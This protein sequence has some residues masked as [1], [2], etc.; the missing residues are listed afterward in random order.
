MKTFIFDLYNTLIDVKTDEHCEKAWAPVVEFFAAKRIKTDWKRL[1]AEFDRYWKLFNERALAERKFQ[2][3]ECDCITQFESIARS[4][5]GRLS[6]DDAAKALCI[7][8]EVSIEKLGLFDG[9]IEL[10]DELH[11]RGCKV[12]LLSNAQAVFTRKEMERVGLADKFDG[13][14]LSSD[15]GV[16]KPDP[17]FYEI[18]FDEYDLDKSD[19]VMTGDD[20]D[21]D[22]RG[23][24]RFGIRGLWANGGAAAHKDEIFGLIG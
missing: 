8:R 21:A 1:C 2:Y 12:Y 22:V 17:A 14:C 19:A 24:E 23:A 11:A 9:T 7:M 16:R 6:R 13:V 20:M 4:V 5:G 10:L 18:L 3:P 15:Y